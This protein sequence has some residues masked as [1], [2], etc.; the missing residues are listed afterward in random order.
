MERPIV[1][2]IVSSLN[3]VVIP[4]M[5]IQSQV[6][7]QL[8]IWPIALSAHPPG[9]KAMQQGSGKHLYCGRQYV[10]PT[11]TEVT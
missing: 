5:Y 8:G 10:S 2:I 7:S 1:A 4:R 11:K 6:Y 9:Y 3:T